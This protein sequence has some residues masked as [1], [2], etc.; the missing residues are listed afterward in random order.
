MTPPNTAFSDGTNKVRRLTNP[1]AGTISTV[2]PSTVSDGP[3]NTSGMTISASVCGPFSLSC[4]P[5]MASFF[6]TLALIAATVS[7]AAITRTFGKASL[8]G[9]RLK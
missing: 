1:S 5:Q 6:S 7:E 9:F 2:S 4:G 8:I 3:S